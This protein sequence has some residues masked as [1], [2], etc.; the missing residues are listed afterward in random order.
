M[1]TDVSL[2]LL[3]AIAICP[4]S[5]MLSVFLTEALCLDNLSPCGKP[6]LRSYPTTCGKS[7][8]FSQREVCP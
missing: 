3:E 4:K 8:G 5:G 2:F 6:Y 1:H 7:T